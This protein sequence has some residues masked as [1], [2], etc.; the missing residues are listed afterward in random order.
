MLKT[1]AQDLNLKEKT[2][3]AIENELADL[4]KVLLT[5]EMGTEAL[6]RKLEQYSYPENVEGLGSPKVN[7]LIWN[8]RSTSMR[9]QDAGSQKNQSTLV[10]S[11]IAMTKVAHVVMK[12]V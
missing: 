2:G 12:K 6:N 11:I 3:P 9:T 7:P 1:I 5:D 8:Q 10:G 4:L